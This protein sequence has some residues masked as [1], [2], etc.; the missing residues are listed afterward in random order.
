MLS[1]A[2][3]SKAK[4]AEYT[5]PAVVIPTV[6][7]NKRM[8]GVGT[9]QQYIQKL[10]LDLAFTQRN[11]LFD[12]VVKSTE[13]RT[14]ELLEVSDGAVT[15]LRTTFNEA[16]SWASVAGQAAKDQPEPIHRN[17]YVLESKD[18]VNQV[19]GSDGKPAP[20]AEAMLVAQRYPDFGKR[21]ALLGAIPDRPIAIGESMT[22][23]ATEFE[24]LLVAGTPPDMKAS[25][26]VES[27]VLMSAD[28]SAAIFDVSGSMA[29]EDNQLRMAV[30]L[31]GELKILLASGVLA[32]MTLEGQVG[33]DLKDGE[34]ARDPTLTIKGKMK[35]KVT[36]R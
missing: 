5:P 21:D 10:D 9:K 16:T 29:F 28:A 26:V 11:R 31:R 15:K 4:E 12:V 35:L 13:T 33:L 32:S 6:T 34:K 2:A 36:V 23:M 24:K 20:A 19:L 30:P 27:I 22:T 18:G 7:I 14:D 17:T 3:C 1:L 25:A 8:P